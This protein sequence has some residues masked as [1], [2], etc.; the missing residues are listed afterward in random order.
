MGIIKGPTLT[1]KSK[2]VWQVDENNK[3]AIK[4]VETLITDV[5]AVNPFNFYPIKGMSKINDGDLIE[6]HSLTKD[7]LSKLIGV[8]GYDQTEVSAYSPCNTRRSLRCS[9]HKQ[10]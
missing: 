1:K 4:T 6:V 5:Y 7:A 2:N 9:Y 10:H 8:P 3:F